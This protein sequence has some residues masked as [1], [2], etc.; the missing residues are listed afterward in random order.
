MMCDMERDWA[1]LGSRLRRDSRARGLQQQDVAARI[2]V[3]RGAI[4]NIEQGV[5]KKVTLTIRAYARLAGWTE[6]S[7]DAVLAGGEPTRDADEEPS[8]LPTQKALSDPGAA[9]EAGLD[10]LSL[11]VLAALGEGT[12][13]D[14]DVLTI[15]IAGSTLRATLVVRGAPD[16]TP[17]QLREALRE[18]E[19]REGALRAAAS[20]DGPSDS[21]Q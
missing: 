3:G 14:S 7:I 18:W 15:P 13:V 2:G 1:R 4:A 8:S 12:L 10:D 11:R 5:A 9:R 19:T 20:G 6:D 21:D 16:M 17:A